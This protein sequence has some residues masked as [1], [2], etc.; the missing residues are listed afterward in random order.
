MRW[1][2]LWGTARRSLGFRLALSFLV[3]FALLLAL[4]GLL[5][6]NTL[7]SIQNTQMQEAI[8]GD[9][10]TMKGFLQ[11]EGGKVSW[12]TQ[13]LDEDTAFVLA[14]LQRMLLVA[15]PS[16]K[17]LEISPSYALLGPETDA[18]I[19]EALR[20]GQVHWRIRQD[21]WGIRYMIRSSVLEAGNRRYYVSIGRALNMN[22]AVVSRFTWRYFL[23]VPI[24]LVTGGVLGWLLT[25]RALR[26]LHDVVRA[27]QSITGSNLS[28]RIPPRGAGDELD[29][30]IETFNRM[31]ERLEQ[32]FEQM[33][34]FTTD[35]SHE[36]R[37]PITAVRGHLEVALMSARSSEELREAISTA[38]EETE[39]LSNVV[40]TML[41]LSQA[42]SGQLALRKEPLELA[43]LTEDVLDQFRIPAEEAGVRLTC[44]LAPNCVAKV[45]R[46]QYER[47]LAN[48]LSNAVK[49][50]GPG[51]QVWV[52][53]KSDRSEVRLW[54]EDT[55]CGIPPEHLPHIFERFYRVPQDNIAGKKG[56]GLGLSFVAWIVKA[57][58]G[59]IAV[60]SRPGQ[61]TRFEVF[62]PKA[63][64]PATV[65]S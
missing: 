15:D 31:M 13:D 3:F 16:G 61:G 14:R 19:Q 27:S 30:L 44:D 62:F 24:I 17:V 57:H 8:E 4:I 49:Y 22:Q 63:P 45:D 29:R 20:N 46:I 39:R 18:E 59:R 65:R 52:G 36:L 2:L 28:L 47:L 7:I 25:R 56:M 23:T 58:G 10:A 43:P 9:W 55:G 51:G 50:T 34:Q 48:L 37:T 60:Q 64:A 12:A 26:P 41:A 35:V 33:R 38:L 32:S 53:L 11:I 42:E 40:K 6:R 1:P 54:V 5:F 21:P